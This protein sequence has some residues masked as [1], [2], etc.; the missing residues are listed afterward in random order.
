MDKLEDNFK[1]RYVEICLYYIKTLGFCTKKFNE[2]KNLICL[3]NCIL[4]LETKETLP[5]SADYYFSRQLPVDYD[6]TADCPEFK[7]FLNDIFLGKQEIIKFVQELIGYILTNSTKAQCFFVFYGIGSNGK[8]VL[9][10]IIMYLVG[11]DNYSAVSIRDLTSNFSRAVLKDKS[12]N[13]STEN[14]PHEGTM[15]DTQYVKAI[16]SG[17]V[18]KA[19]EKFKPPFT[20]KPTCKLIFCTNTLPQFNDKS[21]G[22]LRR[23]KI[24]PFDAHFSIKDGTADVYLEEKLKNELSGILNFALE[25]LDRL[26]QNEYVF[27]E[28]KSMAKLMNRYEKLTNPF[29]DF[30]GECITLKNRNTDLYENTKADFYS[31][32]IQWCEDNK[33]KN[34]AN[35]SPRKFWQYFG[36][37]MIRKTNKKIKFRKSGADRYVT[38]VFIKNKYCYRKPKKVTRVKPVLDDSYDESFNSQED[39]EI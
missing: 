3:R 11:E 32:F 28:S 27:T 10:N 16:A 34:Y 21:A 5:H 30:W 35:I 25:G 9:A 1:S 23:I 2:Y 8:S 14:E 19:E 37:V 18:I 33:H 31:T 29:D 4:N 39:D 13:I 17:D 6:K 12:L 20:F 24:I 15:L 26:I 22:F 7:K 38:N 36:E